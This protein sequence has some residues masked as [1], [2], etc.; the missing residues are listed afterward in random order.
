MAEQAFFVLHDEL[1]GVVVFL[2]AGRVHVF[3]LSLAAL[4]F[5]L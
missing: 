1:V 4:G 3:A 5:E 2:F